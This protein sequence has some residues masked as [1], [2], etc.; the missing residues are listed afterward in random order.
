MTAP[1]SLAPM[2]ALA[3][4]DLFGGDGAACALPGRAPD[5]PDVGHE[6]LALLGASGCRL[7]PGGLLDWHAASARTFFEEAGCPVP[8]TLGQLDG[9]LDGAATLAL[10]T[11]QRLS[12]H[13]G[14]QVDVRAERAGGIL[15]LRRLEPPVR[16]RA[17]VDPAV[18]ALSEALAEGR[19]RLYRQPIVAANDDRTVVRW[20]CLARLVRADGSVASPHEFIPAAERSGLIGQ[21]DIAALTLALQSLA[22]RPDE[23][24]AVNVSA[25][26]LADPAARE[27]YLGRLRAHHGAVQGLTVEIT[28]TI[29][30]HD[31]DVA[32]RFAEEARAPGIRIALDDFGEGYTSFQSLMRLPLDEVKIDGLYVQDIDVRADSQAFVRAIEGLSRD[33]GL[34]T[35]A[36]RVE[37]RAEAAALRKLGIH[38]LQGYYFGA[39]AAG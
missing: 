9:L 12:A 22:V 17:P 39:P 31:L 8:G 1:P 10:A 18:Q 29:A 36:E 5:L 21:L 38:G 35:V 4:A 15:V 37:T 20:E 3:D 33:L 16:T 30:I 32:A 7:L 34:E 2:A 26:T 25:A 24:L 23:A 11:G 14:G 6:A 28:E 19:M 13:L 27:D